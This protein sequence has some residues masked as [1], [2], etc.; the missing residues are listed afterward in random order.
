[1]Q[2]VVSQKWDEQRLYEIILKR[3]LA[4]QMSDAVIERT[5][6]KIE[7]DSCGEQFAATGEVVKFDGYLKV[8][9]DTP[10]Q[11]LSSVLKSLALAVRPRM[12][13]SSPRL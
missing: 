12:R 2:P 8:Y 1:M 10:R 3:T 13:P 4:S 9:S 5:N 11:A 7:A 6:I